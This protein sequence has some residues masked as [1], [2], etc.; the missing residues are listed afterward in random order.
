MQV[1]VQAV[2]FL[3]RYTS[4]DVQ[5]VQVNVRPGATVRGLLGMLDIPRGEVL[6]VAVN[7]Q[8]VGL[9]HVLCPDDDV[10]VIPPIG[11]G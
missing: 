2:G 7:D 5:A 1:R 4:R 10:R 3:K 11:G 6:R 8:I 9:D